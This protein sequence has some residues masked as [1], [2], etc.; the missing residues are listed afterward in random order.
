MKKYDEYLV[1]YLETERT[2]SLHKIGTFF[3]KGSAFYNES[4]HEIQDGETQF[5]MDKKT[6]TSPGL[7]E[8]IASLTGKNATLISSD[9]ESYLDEGRQ[10]INI[11]DSFSIEG[12]GS[13]NKNNSGA[14]I[15]NAGPPIH[16]KIKQEKEKNIH[17]N[18]HRSYYTAQKKKSS[19]KGFMMFFAFF[20]L[21]LVLAGMGWGIYKLYFENEQA[22]SSNTSVLPVVDST[23]TKMPTA[24]DTLKINKPV[25]LSDTSTYM[26][27]FEETPSRER[28]VTRTAKLHDFGNPAL[29]DSIQENGKIIYRLYLL[30]KTKTIADTSRIRD[31]IFRYFQ[32]T[33]KVI[34]AHSF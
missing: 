32:R 6:L 13:I 19:N 30:Q 26:F 28:A 27:V 15:F 17:E 24:T 11:G 4:T 14:Y 33:I 16:L 9:M 21:L 3:K 8:F 34:P 1:Q 18:E 20:I 2:L 10:F 5:S 22:V 29:Y 25:I 31:S 23:Q 7:I 12:I